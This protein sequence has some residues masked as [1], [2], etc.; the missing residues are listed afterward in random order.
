MLNVALT[1]N[2]AAGKTTVGACFARWGATLIDADELVRHVQAPGSPVLAAIAEEFGAGMIRNDGTLDRA[3]LRRRVMANQDALTA[4]NSIVHPAVQQ[5]RAQRTEE[6]IHAG[7]CILVNDIPLL[8]EVLDPAQFDLVVLV[9]A[10]VNV[11]RQRLVM[12]RRLPPHE[13]DR[14]MTS[15]MDAREKR[16]RSD[17]VIDNAGSLADLER[18]AWD[19]WQALRERAARAIE[20]RGATLLTVLAHPDDGAFAIGGSLARYAEAGAEIHLASATSGGAGASQEFRRASEILGARDIHLLGY[21]DGGLSPDSSPG[22]VAVESLLRQLAPAVVITFGPDGITGHPDHK[23]VHHWTLTA[24]QACGSSGLLYYITYP[25]HVAE[26]LGRLASRREEE[27]VTAL[28]IRPWQDVKRAAIA[29]HASQRFPFELGAPETVPLFEREWFAG[30]RP[31]T[32]PR[33]E[34]F[35]TL[36]TD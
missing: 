15:Q 12:Q 10:P 21:P 34:L 29:A 27:I 30:V 8:F 19:V 17:Y 28:D 3:R 1:G 5:M 16:G 7:V 33:A 11:R 18:A 32:V 26:R 13:A 9:D 6:A 35:G 25:H 2:T 20:V 36:D 4:L 14:L 22:V 23:A 24:W 31:G